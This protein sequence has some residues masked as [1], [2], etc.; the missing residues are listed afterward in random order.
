M[1]KI[2]PDKLFFKIGETSEIADLPTHVLRFWEN[3]FKL[4]S[5]GKNRTGQRLYT[6]RDV[7]IILRIK[8][9]LYDE[10]YTIAGAG[11][12]LSKEFGKGRKSADDTREI[13]I[14]VKKGLKN[15]LR[16]LK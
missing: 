12:R 15:I 1:A 14:R 4:L 16:D 13:L 7:E 8:E 3:E 11:Q 10:K 9:L 2:I 6:R 5:P